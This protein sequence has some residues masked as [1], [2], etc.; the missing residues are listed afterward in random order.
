M[1]EERE[2]KGEKKKVKESGTM[3]KKRESLKERGEK[4]KKKEIKKIK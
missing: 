2:K 1:K 4:K 3:E